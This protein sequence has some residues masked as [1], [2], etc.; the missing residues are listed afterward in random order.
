LGSLS[1]VEKVMPAYAAAFLPV[2][3]VILIGDGRRRGGIERPAAAFVLSYRDLHVSVSHFRLGLV[4]RK[5][6]LSIVVV[7]FLS[8][9]CLSHKFLDCLGL[10]ARG[11]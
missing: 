8:L 6:N 7:G 4:F 2:A 9:L 11:V 10:Q 5:R 1:E 3:R